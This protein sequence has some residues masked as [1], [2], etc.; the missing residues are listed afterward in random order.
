MIG[1]LEVGTESNVD[2]AKSI[3]SYLM[4]LLPDDHYNVEGVDNTNACY[5]GTAALLNTLSW[6]QVTGRY[7][8]VVATDT[9][10]MDVKDS[11]WRGAS[12]VAMLVGPNP[13]IEIHPERMSC[14]KNTHDFLKPRYSN[15]IS[16]VMQTKASM[17]YYVHALDYTLEKMKQEHLID[18][19]AFDAFVFH[20]G[21]CAT[22][23]KLI[24]RHV[25]QV[26]KASKAWRSNF[27]LAR[28]A[29]SQMGGLYTAS[30]YINLLSLLSNI[31][32]TDDVNHIGLFSYGS[33]ST[34]ACNGSSRSC[35]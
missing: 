2:M 14:F 27:E 12:A 10:D 11:A 34:V 24:E 9:A 5:G 21:L 28:A 18:A 7:G 31:E 6:C 35:T 8:I 30:L 33:G 23:M 3:K 25:M 4:D 16:P 20:G 13:W 1:R 17:D 32:G 22:F 29:A 19:E 15:Q 26:V